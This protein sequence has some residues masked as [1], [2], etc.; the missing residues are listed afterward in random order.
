MVHRLVEEYGDRIKVVYR[1]LP[2]ARHNYALIAAEAAEAAGEQGKFW[3]MESRLFANQS[4]LS[5][6]MI[7]ETARSIG[8]DMARF[9][10]A[11]VQHKYLGLIQA[12]IE[13]AKRK[14]V[15]G[16]PTF[17]VGQTVLRGLP[18]WEKLEAAVLQELKK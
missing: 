6:E 15:T 7:Y 8:L 14:G 13:E 4:S 1:H 16:T 11:M 9:R 12:D 10:D 17:F 2:L 18:S 3:E 5:E